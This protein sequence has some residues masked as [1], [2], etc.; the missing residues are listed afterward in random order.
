MAISLA[1]G[2]IGGAAEVFR[3]YAGWA[4]KIYGRTDVGENQVLI[5][6][7]R[8][9]TFWE[10]IR[11]AVGTDSRDETQLLFIDHAHHVV[12]QNSHMRPFINLRPD[13]FA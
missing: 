4:T 11:R 13:H 6:P 9:S 1:R 12:R 3:Y 8:G 2:M 7:N 5:I 10:E